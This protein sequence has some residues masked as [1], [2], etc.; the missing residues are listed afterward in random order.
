MELLLAYQV[1]TQV[2][3]SCDGQ[4]S[5]TFDLW[6]LTPNKGL[7]QPPDDPVAYGKAIYQALFPPGTPASHALNE[8]LQKTPARI[9]LVMAHDDL[10]AVPWEYAYGPEGFLVLEC[11]FVRGLPAGQRIPVPTLDSG[12]HILA[13][14]SN[15]L[16]KDTPALNID[17]EWMRLREIVEKV[18][19]AITLERTRPPTMEQTRA[20][21][22]NQHHRVVHF[23]GHGGQHK[24]IGAFLCFEKD[25]G[26][27][28]R[29]TARQLVLRVRG[30]VFLVTLN[31]C[32]SATPGPTLFSNLASALVQQKVPYALGMRFSILDEDARAFSRTFYNDLARGTPVEESLLQTRLTLATSPRSWVVGVPVLYTSLAQAAAGFASR[33]GTPT[34]NAYQPRMEVS[35]LP[36]AEGAFQGR[37]DELKALGK[38]LTGDSRPRIITIHGGGGQGKTAL[39]REAIERFAHSWLGGVWA[40][41]LENLPDRATFTTDLA[42][43]LGI[44]TQE[45]A[46]PAEV[47][48]R[49]LT[50]LMQR[51]VLLV[52]DNA[53][54]FIDAVDA[55]NTEAINFGQFIQQLPGP[56]VSLLVTSRVSLGWSGEELL[57]L[58]GLSPKEGVDLFLQCTPRRRLEIEQDTSI[59]DLSEKLEGHP[60][61]LRLLATAFDVSHIPLSDFIYEYEQHLFNAEDKYRNLDHRHRS[62]NTCIEMSVQ[63]L[64][65]DP[66][67][68]LSGLWVFHA[69]F[70]TEAAVPIFDP[71]H[72]DT[73]EHPSPIRAC[74]YTLYQR[75]L[76]ARV[77]IPVRDATLQFYRLLPTT[78]SYVEHHLQKT[79]EREKL[80]AQFGTVYSRL[81]DM[82]Y[83][84]LG[85]S[86]E[87]VTIAQQAREDL[88]QGIEHVTG[89][90]RGYYLL[91]CG[92]ILHRLGNPLSGLALLERALE[93][94]QEQDQRLESQVLNDLAGVYVATGQPQKALTLYEQALPIRREVGERAGE[95]TTLNNMG[96]VY[97]ITGQ[98]QKALTLYEQALPIT[99]EVRDRA[100][101]ATILNNLAVV[102]ADTGQPQKALTLYQ[103][104][105]SIHREVGNRTME[106]T[107]LNNLGGVYRAT[108]QPQKAL[109]LYEQA[110]SIMREVS[111]RAGEATILNNLV[112][113]RDALGQPQEALTLYE[114]ALS[115]TREV[116]D[117]AG[118]AT[119]LN[120]M[121][122]VYRDTG[123]PQKAL[124]LYQQALSIHREVGDRVGEA[125][126]LNN[127][128]D[129]YRA[130]GQ[131]Q[132]ALTLYEQALSIMREVSNRAGEATILNNLAVV[133][134]D[135]GQPQKALTLYQQ[136]LSIHREVGDRA[137]EA[138]TLNG[139]A[140]VYQATGQ[141]QKALTLYEQALSIHREVGD[142]AG[143]A[144][145]LNNLADVYRATGQPQEALA[146][147]QQALPIMREVSNR[148][149][150]VATLN[151]MGE[152]Y[153]ATG[154]PQEALTLYEQVLP[155]RREVGDRVGEVATL[156]NMAG[157]HNALGQP[158]KALT[159]YEQALSIV[160]EVGDQDAEAAVLNGL[161]YL[162]QG[163]HHYTEALVAFEQS[164]TIARQIVNPAAEVA[165]LVGMALLLYQHFNRTEEAIM[166]MERSIALL[167]NTGLPQD[168]TGQTPEELRFLLVAMRA[169]I[170]LEEL[171]DGSAAIPADELQEIVDNTIAVMTSE[172]EHRTEWHEEMAGELQYAQ[173]QGIE[174][175]LEV[176][177]FTAILTILDGLIP[178]LSS[179]H[180]YAQAIATIQEGIATKGKKKQHIS[181]KKVKQGKTKHKKHKHSKK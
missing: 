47:E 9:L 44:P 69:P 38:H 37:I 170:S 130:T 49:V 108:G 127:L 142:R 50:I 84:D 115:I 59:W 107:T 14:P 63:Y 64:D 157:T 106:A 135:T 122:E 140:V 29:V 15:P 71:K 109:T 76:L 120:N 117:R 39:A 12:L 138:T 112:G 26:D 123:Q 36:R 34:I 133:Y 173:Q 129:V 21:L 144:T 77:T 155:I 125:T 162:L 13:V 131:P 105:L 148:V 177:F 145:T 18:P 95:A 97:R 134:Q 88:E 28:D 48:R 101:E 103:Q 4:P 121:G 92:W 55:K 52:L 93:I 3:V 158:Q 111:N 161:A 79:C 113:I 143:E 70:L 40:T 87:V 57:E 118:E 8:E 119:T 167:T 17:G 172:W 114:Q 175:Q 151:N 179:D 24:D 126:T 156:A 168:A 53:E 20:L 80:L 62:L 149:G 2:S 159:L 60:F 90:V 163:M 66:R 181:Q 42:R 58:G 65:A 169:G 136:A 137:G 164:I 78:R 45:I 75:S 16:D 96:E 61:G 6:T 174:R 102:Y 43:F 141:P 11:H 19:Y 7:L 165:G 146:L 25:T 150:E 132:K 178:T 72:E 31:A 180:P 128:A 124:T 153:R 154:Q 54:T 176:D 99:R 46:D 5:H 27:L 22:A 86:A 33:E 116:R 35:A 85:R 81:A 91:S 74:L 98:P 30:T 23:M 67:S 51:R 10:D 110:L 100:R 94:S 89:E 160:R 166:R 32:V 1:G 152:V 104:A 56:S 73:E 171:A 68:L 82:I 139:L 147:Y 83:Y 41:S